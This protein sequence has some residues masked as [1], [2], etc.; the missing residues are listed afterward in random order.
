MSGAI[1]VTTGSFIFHETSLSHLLSEVS[2]QGSETNLL[3]CQYSTTANCGAKEDAAVV[4]QGRLELCVSY[5]TL[6]VNVMMPAFFTA[7]STPSGNCSNGEIRLEGIRDDTQAVTR[8]GRVGICINNAWGTI[9]GLLFGR[10]DA[11]VV[12]GQLDG[13]QRE[14]EVFLLLS[15][16]QGIPSTPQDAHITCRM[17]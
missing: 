10:E 1:A 16:Y 13:F 15:V 4:C 17:T 14:G 6:H 12:C 11:E 8:E 7:I 3:L 2:C 9:C 5:N